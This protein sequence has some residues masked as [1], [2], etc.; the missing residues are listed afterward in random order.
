MSP[1]STEEIRNLKQLELNLRRG[2][3]SKRLAGWTRD[4]SVEETASWSVAAERMSR[5]V[6][7]KQRKLQEAIE[8][9]STMKDVRMADECLDGLGGSLSS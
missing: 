6:E 8:K 3:A 5:E 7:A 2:T 1:E 4:G 9:E